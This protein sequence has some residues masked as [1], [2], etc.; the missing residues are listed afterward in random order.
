MKPQYIIQAALITIFGAALLIKGPATFKEPKQ[1]WAL[2]KGAA[3]VFLGQPRYYQHSS[4]VYFRVNTGPRRGYYY[5]RPYYHRYP[6]RGYYYGRSEVYLT[7]RQ[8]PNSSEN[9]TNVHIDNYRVN[10]RQPSDRGYRGNY[11]YRL[12]PGDHSIEWTIEKS[13]GRKTQYQRQFYV[14]RYGRPVNITIDG[15]EFYRN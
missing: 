5:G 11:T 6:Y 10:L 12:S 8:D 4:R 3:G 1:V 7:V 14:D 2:N 9:I 15:D 13:R